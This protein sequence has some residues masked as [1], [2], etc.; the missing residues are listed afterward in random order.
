MRQ[1]EKREYEPRD[2]FI[3]IEKDEYDDLVQDATFGRIFA[4]ILAKQTAY[5]KKNNYVPY[6]ETSE[7]LLRLY[8]HSLIFEE[9]PPE[10]N[11][12]PRT[13]ASTLAKLMRTYKD[14]HGED[15][16]DE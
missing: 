1:F 7:L 14:N 15:G 9:E 8:D 16:E 5:Y 2:V 4:E 3:E 12:E 11:D 10:Q 6:D 13:A